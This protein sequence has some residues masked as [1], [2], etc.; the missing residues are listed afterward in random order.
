MGEVI[1]LGDHKARK[2]GFPEYTAVGT[3]TDT[4]GNKCVR[5]APKDPTKNNP[6]QAVQYRAQ[7]TPAPRDRNYDYIPG[8]VEQQVL[9][10]QEL[11]QQ[12]QDTMSYMPQLRSVQAR[13]QAVLDSM[14]FRERADK[15]A[16]SNGWVIRKGDDGQFIISPKEQG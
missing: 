14:K 8:A 12:A 11:L 3:Y 10:I 1:S 9:A 13:E 2:M 16:A 6:I 4:N 5:L 15:L 7:A